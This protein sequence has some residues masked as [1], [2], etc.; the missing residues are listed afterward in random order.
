MTRSPF[1]VAVSGIIL[2]LGKQLGSLD[3]GGCRILSGFTLLI[4]WFNKV[5]KGK[6]AGSL[7]AFQTRMLFNIFSAACYESRSVNIR[8]FNS[9]W[10]WT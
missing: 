9:C 7:S 3:V 5:M 1:C 2:P 10:V 6:L 4:I 8:L